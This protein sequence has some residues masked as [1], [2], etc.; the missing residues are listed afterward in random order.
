M[1]TTRSQRAAQ[2]TRLAAANDN[3]NR[4]QR[5]RRYRKNYKP[6]DSSHRHRLPDP[7]RKTIQVTSHTRRA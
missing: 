7:Q 3:I 1:V 6:S 5:L 4:M 2:G